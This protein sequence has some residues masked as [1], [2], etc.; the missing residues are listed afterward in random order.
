MNE[1]LAEAVLPAGTADALGIVVTFSAAAFRFNRSTLAGL[2]IIALS[3]LVL[4]AVPSHAI[5]DGPNR[6]SVAPGAQLK[7]VHG[8]TVVI[9]SIDRSNAGTELSITVMTGHEEP[10][11]S[12]VALSDGQR[13]MISVADEHSEDTLVSYAFRRTGDKV[14]MTLP[15]GSNPVCTGPGAAAARTPA[16]PG[17]CGIPEPA[18]ADEEPRPWG[19]QFAATVSREAA[20]RA[21]D[22]GLS[23][24]SPEMVE[25]GDTRVDRQVVGGRNLY[26]AQ[27]LFDTR[28][29]ARRLCEHVIG[30]GGACVVRRN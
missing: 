9:A 15:E 25:A 21:L 28:A 16:G 18:R 2:A 3:Y 8:S 10:L 13:F 23:L 24:L 29:D 1:F 22:R 5:A 27:L 17:G 4:G 26:T 11:Q 7:I 12:R 6:V 30:N 20:E 19:V 14:E